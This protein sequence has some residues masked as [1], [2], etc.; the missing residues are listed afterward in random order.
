MLIRQRLS[1]QSPNL[2]EQATNFQRM[3]KQC[4]EHAFDQANLK[5]KPEKA[6]VVNFR[7]EDSICTQLLLWSPYNYV[8]VFSRKKNFIGENFG[9]IRGK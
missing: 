6:M 1:C 9:H 2:F 8:G 5:R 7:M 4:I 3:I